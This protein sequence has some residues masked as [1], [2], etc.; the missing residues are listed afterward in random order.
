M[1]FSGWTANSG[2]VAI[3]A[4][5]NN[6]DGK[7]VLL[8]STVFF[9]LQLFTCMWPPYSL[10]YTQKPQMAERKVKSEGGLSA[11]PTCKLRVDLFVHSCATVSDKFNSSLN[12][13]YEHVQNC[14][15]LF[16]HERK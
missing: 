12:P 7:S 5:Y 15:T 3:N 9:C 1:P 10:W 6:N 16:E 2:F 14:S 13:K 11:V 8:I 4:T